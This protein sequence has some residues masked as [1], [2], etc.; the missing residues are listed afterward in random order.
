MMV[1]FVSDNTHLPLGRYL[2]C[3][4]QGNTQ[5]DG[6]KEQL[7]TETQVGSWQEGE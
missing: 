6:R 3:Y 5:R 2:D 1:N 4:D 7:R